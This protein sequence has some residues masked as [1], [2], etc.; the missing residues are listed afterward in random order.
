MSI[1][2]VFFKIKGFFAYPPIDIL[3]VLIIILIGSAGFGLGRLSA[4]QDNVVPVTVI[5]QERSAQASVST[6]ST[7]ITAPSDSVVAS[8]VGT[9]YHFPWCPGAQQISEKNKITFISAEEAR[10]SGYTPAAN[11]KGLE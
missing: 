2:D 3:V 6:A 4:L 1:R 10:A 5:Q 7:A 9:K 8:K 11:C